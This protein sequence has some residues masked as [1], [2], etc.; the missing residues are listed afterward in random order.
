MQK[1]LSSWVVAFARPLL[2]KHVPLTA[3][4]LGANSKWSLTVSL[5]LKLGVEIL[6]WEDPVDAAK[7]LCCKLFCIKVLF[8]FPT[9]AKLFG[10]VGNNV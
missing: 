10:A 7:H 1:Q 2:R 5:T 8:V 9:D 3:S 4:G 6:P